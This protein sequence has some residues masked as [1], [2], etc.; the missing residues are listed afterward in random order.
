MYHK[1]MIETS[2]NLFEGGKY[3][4]ILVCQVIPITYIISTSQQYWGLHDILK[5]P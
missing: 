2:P 4:H 1:D 3:L 5:E